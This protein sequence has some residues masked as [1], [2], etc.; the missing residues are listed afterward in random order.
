M[1]LIIKLHELDSH[2]VFYPALSTIPLYCEITHTQ[3]TFC[4]VNGR[5]IA[6]GHPIGAFGCCILVT[7][8]YSLK[9]QGGKRGVAALCIGR[10]MGIAMLCRDVLNAHES[11]DGAVDIV[12]CCNAS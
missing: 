7:L 12:C 1:L 9:K 10:G 8:L 4:H 5:A 2:N 11:S 3:L 6:L